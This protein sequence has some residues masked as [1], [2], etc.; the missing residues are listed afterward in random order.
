MVRHDGRDATLNEIRQRGFMIV[1]AS[2]C[3]RNQIHKCVTCRRLRGKMGEQKMADLPEE[4]CSEAAP[5][6]YTG[7]DMFG[8]FV[9]KEG[10]KEIQRYVA[11]FTCL[12]S[13]CIHGEYQQS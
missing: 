9:I 3:V 11:I 8:P 4:R 1:N 7:V 13:R 10:R 6:T 12:S 2:S 5:F